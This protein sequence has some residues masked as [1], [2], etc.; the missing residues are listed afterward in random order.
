MQI[1]QLNLIFLYANEKPITNLGNNI[2][3]ISI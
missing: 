3:I 2:N 1:S